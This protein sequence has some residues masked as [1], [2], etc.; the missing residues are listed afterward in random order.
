MAAAGPGRIRGRR[1][2]ELLHELVEQRGWLPDSEQA[3]VAVAL[4]ALHEQCCAPRPAPQ[5]GAS[6]ASMFAAWSPFTASPSAPESGTAGHGAGGVYVYGPVGSGKTAL[7]DVCLEA[8][9]T[10]GV[11]TRRL[12]F[13]QARE[14]RPSHLPRPCSAANTGWNT[15]HRKSQPQHQS[16]GAALAPLPLHTTVDHGTAH[17]PSSQPRAHYPPAL[18]LSLSFFPPVP[19]DSVPPPPH[20]PQLMQEAHALLHAKQSIPQIGRLLGR[21][22][23]SILRDSV[24]GGSGWGAGVDGW[25]GGAGGG[26][27]VGGMGAS[28]QTGPATGPKWPSSAA[29]PPSPSASLSLLRLLAVDEFQMTDI[30]DAAILSRLTQGEPGIDGLGPAA[31]P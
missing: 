22:T 21:S 18:P 25:Y 12:H 9:E 31:R 23:R 11:P 14:G 1:P 10:A 29:A 26:D 5:P 27:S 2:S 4:D 15:S 8:C 16:I 17:A 13:H 3:A 6:S 24:S 20:P 28:P 30:A 19:S 7:M